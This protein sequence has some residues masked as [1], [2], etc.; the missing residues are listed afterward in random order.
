MTA[1][2]LLN[3]NGADDTIDCLGSIYQMQGD[4]FVV[5]ADNGSEDDSVARIEDYLHQKSVI[6][7]I[8][9][10]GEK[11]E[12]QPRKG[13]CFVITM[14]D[15]LGF[16]RGNNEVLRMLRNSHVQAD[17]YLLLNNDTV[18]EA[19][20]LV[21]LNQ[22]SIQHPD[23]E[24]LTPLICYFSNREKVWNAGGKLFCGLRK[25]Y[26]SDRPVSDI[27]EQGHIAITFV[28]G[29]AL[30]VM[31]S[32]LQEDGSLLTERFFFGEEDFEFSLRMKKE[33]RKMA[34]VLDSRIY[35]KVN[36]S[37]AQ[38]SSAAKIYI[39][40]L[41]RFIDM[42]QHSSAFVY[43]LWSRFYSLYVVA[44]LCR[45]GFTLADSSLLMKKVLRRSLRQEGV[46]QADFLRALACSEVIQL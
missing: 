2:I 14:G 27:C 6:L 39:Y 24:A 4:F 40:Y 9:D 22:F 34:C 36:S 5:V 7:T 37:V 1:I 46:S 30:Y 17:C 28:T 21:R 32:L 19:D 13:E 41:N 31:P 12:H 38:K 8:L 18:V 15:N 20:F 23:I 29:C 35:H 25:Y 33:G 45:S 43:T 42:R 3:W 44:L 10:H 11:M 26:Y 16:A